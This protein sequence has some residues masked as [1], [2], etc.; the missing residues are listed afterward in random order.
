MVCRVKFVLLK[1][2]ALLSL[3]SCI[4]HRTVVFIQS[5]EDSKTCRSAGR[6]MEMGRRA[7]HSVVQS[8]VAEEPKEKPM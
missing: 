3:I 8:M 5:E 6:A 7:G 4:V 1:G 2:V